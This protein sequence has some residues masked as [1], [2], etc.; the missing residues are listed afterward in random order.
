MAIKYLD[1]SG[2]TRYDSKIKN[3]IATKQDALVSGTNI[4]TINNTSILGSGNISISG[5]T[6]TDVQINGTSI[7]SNNVADIQTN[8]TYNSISNKIATMSDIISSGFVNFSGGGYCKNVSSWN[9]VI[10][11]TW[12]VKTT[13]TYDIYFEGFKN[14]TNGNG[15]FSVGVLNDWNDLT[16]NGIENWFPRV[17]GKTFEQTW[18]WCE[19]TESTKA[20]NVWSNKSLLYDE[21]VIICFGGSADIQGGFNISIVKTS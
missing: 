9:N 16:N 5:G 7:T 15:G 17:S 6:P 10:C 2:L 12:R 1:D 13:G 4:K 21:R 11:M 20:S 14:Q 18:K 19:V 3:V 8:G